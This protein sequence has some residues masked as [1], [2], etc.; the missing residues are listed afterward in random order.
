LF[1]AFFVAFGR[2]T[3][4]RAGVRL[5]LVFAI[6]IPRRANTLHGGRFHRSALFR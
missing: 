5:D 4:A 2:L 6:L 3:P 1:A